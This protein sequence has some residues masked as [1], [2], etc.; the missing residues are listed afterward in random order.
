MQAQDRISQPLTK[1][2]VGLGSNDAAVSAAGG[3]VQSG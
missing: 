2:G 3:W 1:P